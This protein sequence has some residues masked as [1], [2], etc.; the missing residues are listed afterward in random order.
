MN[1]FLEKGQLT[2]TVQADDESHSSVHVNVP[3]RKTNSKSKGKDN[4][5][6]YENFANLVV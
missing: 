6:N 1:N 5:G 3:K 4:L 2:Y